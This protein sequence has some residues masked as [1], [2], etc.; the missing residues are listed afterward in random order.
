[1]PKSLEKQ[2]ED[3]PNELRV[4]SDPRTGFYRIPCLLM[5]WM[6]DWKHVRATVLWVHPLLVNHLIEEQQKEINESC[7]SFSTLSLM[8]ISLNNMKHI[9]SDPNPLQPLLRTS[10]DFAISIP[11][12]FEGSSSDDRL[13]WR[14]STWIHLSS[15]S[16]PLDSSLLHLSVHDH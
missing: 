3:D 1:M 6:P 14:K 10:T 15:S 8:K 7:H 13:W 2:R 16:H 9:K 5:S 12:W 4:K 11:F